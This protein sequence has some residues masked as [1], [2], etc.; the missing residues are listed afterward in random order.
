MFGLADL[1]Q[2][3]GRVGRYNRKAYAYFLI[4]RGKPISDDASRRLK[5]IAKHSELGAGFKVAMYDL[6]IRGAGNILGP[7][8]HGFIQAIGFDLYCRL[9]RQTIYELTT[10]ERKEK[11]VSTL[12]R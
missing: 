7:Q 6:E 9:L 1:Y 11:M 12:F 10:K 2:L 8:Q 5:T 4:P 3:R